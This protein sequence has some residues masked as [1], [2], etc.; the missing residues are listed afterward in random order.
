[1]AKSNRQHAC[2][3]KEAGGCG[4]FNQW[5]KAPP[6]S[7]THSKKRSAE[8]DASNKQT[9]KTKRDVTSSFSK[10]LEE[11]LSLPAEKASEWAE[12]SEFKEISESLSAP[13]LTR[14]SSLV[15]LDEYDESMYVDSPH[16]ILLKAQITEKVNMIKKLEDKAV[17]REN[18]LKKLQ[19]EA[20]TYEEKIK[21]L[22]DEAIQ[23]ET[24]L[25][26]REVALKQ[27]EM[28]LERRLQKAAEDIKIVRDKEMDLECFE[29]N[30]RKREADVHLCE[31]HASDEMFELMNDALDDFPVENFGE[32]RIVFDPLVFAE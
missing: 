28:D 14:G 18:Q 13:K 26:L 12:S 17:E 24:Q 19:A 8:S 22:E 31:V 29:K 7:R 9:K 16:E 2:P 15:P 3:S 23:R 25:K 30:L 1:M 10:W 27:R 6:K 32:D 4:A 20:I 11:E 21:K 5:V